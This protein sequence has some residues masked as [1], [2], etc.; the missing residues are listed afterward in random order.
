MTSTRELHLN[1]N[2]LNAGT[3][4]SAWRWPGS[5]PGDFAD[6]QHYV[7]NAQLAEKGTFD[8]VFLAD[9]LSLSDRPDYRPFQSHE[10]T[11]VLATI[12]AATSHIGLIATASRA[13]SPPWTTPAADA[14][15]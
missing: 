1:L 5:N 12:A 11:I 6:I 4:G 3:Y 2:F 15:G 10:P 13:A 8:A 14:P 7:R 9:M